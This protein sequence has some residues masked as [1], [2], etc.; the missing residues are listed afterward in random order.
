MYYKD[1]NYI[2][3]FCP[4]SNKL[5]NLKLLKL[6]N[7]DSLKLLYLNARSIQNKIEELNNIINKIDS[8]VHLVAITETWL[9][10]DSTCLNVNDYNKI[11]VSRAG[12]RIGGGCALLIHK[13]I[14]SYEL[15]NS[16]TDEFISILSV[17]ICINNNEFL[18]NVVYNP[19]NNCVNFLK[20]FEDYLV[21]LKSNNSVIIGDMNINLLNC[22]KNCENYNNLVSVN[23]YY[24]CDNQTPTR[25]ESFAVLDHVLINN[26]N[27]NITIN[28]IECSI[29]DHNLLVCE[30]SKISVPKEQCDNISIK[31]CIDYKKIVNSLK[32]NP[33]NLQVSN[34]N[35][36]CESFMNEL[37][38]RIEQSSSTT[39]RKFKTGN[40]KLKPWIDDKLMKVIECK[41][42]WY[43]KV[44]KY[45]NNNFQIDSVLVKL[46][47]EYNYWCNKFTSLKRSNRKQYFDKKFVN[48][49]GSSR[50]IWNSVKDVITDGVQ[51]LKKDIQIKVNNLIIKDKNEVSNLFNNHFV[52]SGEE[53][54]KMLNSNSY[55]DNSGIVNDG[56]ILTPTNEIEVGEIIYHLKNTHTSGMDGIS[57]KMLKVCS[58]HLCKQ[59][60]AIINESFVEGVFPSCLKISKVIPVFKSGSKFDINNYRP[61]TLT[62]VISKIIEI[63][64]K[65]RLMV[66]L[67]DN[68]ILSNCQY[69]FRSQCN[70]QVALFDIIT[71]IEK[72]KFKGN[73][74][75]AVFIDLQ[76]AFDT[77]D[78]QILQRKL[79]LIGFSTN[80][81]NWISS[82]VQNRSQMVYVNG[83]Y[84]SVKS[85]KLGVPQGS[86]LGP[87][88]FL[89]YINNIENLKLNG[90]LFLYAD[91]IALV[92][93]EQVYPELQQSMNADL[94]LIKS[95]MSNNRLHLNAKKTKFMIFN[96]SNLSLDIKYD[97]IPIERV[98]KFKYLGVTI[99]CCLK[100]NVYIDLLKIRLSR[101]A[102]IF[103][104]ISSVLSYSTKRMVFFA[105]F[106]SIMDYG[107]EI[108]GKSCKTKLK[109]LQVL[110][111]RALKNLFN[112]DHYTSTYGLHK[113]LNIFPVNY[114][115]QLKLLTL[116]HNVKN[117][118]LHNNSIII[119]N[120]SVHNYNTRSSNFIHNSSF[121]IN[122]ILSQLL[123]YN[124]I[125]TPY[126]LLSKTKFANKIYDL[127][128]LNFLNSCN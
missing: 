58:K 119:N 75:S 52:S 85:C 21:N 112:F 106:S 63:I 88:L 39:V 10:E 81:L 105:F 76:K 18:I 33:I 27:L 47:A 14:T 90:Q 111:N 96:Q 100:F 19:P 11:I 3:P 44:K 68:N 66:Y 36:M 70:T 2:L 78:H 65:I 22:D 20:I 64:F 104:R 121:G 93:G 35:N 31:K 126:T 107:I 113:T 122:S 25:I 24:V 92:Y 73:K 59:I 108:Y 17:K 67:N 102:G 99:D 34:V 62:S 57:S 40:L 51:Q 114:K 79:E 61:I 69:G 7:S 60:A 13:S 16:Y 118:F 82:F 50:G 1:L 97:N 124:T 26:T 91:D 123:I 120:N 86:V 55:L 72:N 23:D 6:N 80:A 42:F 48:N 128:F 56:F 94:L 5:T 95:W 84:S 54:G 117:N 30:F 9:K 37:K 103:R 41:H 49:I 98:K 125:S 74:A 110:Q 115:F 53:L 77:V 116:V 8:T 101:A 45:K 83:H 32:L 29:S 28:N 127:V 12:I 15:V 109:E 89:L 4:V 38:G 87:I 46:K 43:T 71:S